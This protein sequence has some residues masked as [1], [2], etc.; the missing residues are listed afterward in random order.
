M[1]VYI[2]FDER[3][4]AAYDVAHASLVSRSSVPLT[5]SP[6]N[7][8]SLRSSGLY[9]RNIDKRGGRFYDLASSAPCSTDFASSRFLTPIIA[10]SGWALFVD[11]DV[12]FLDD[13]AKMFEYCDDSKA[14]VLVKHNY[15][16]MELTKM[17]GQIQTMYNRKNW[18][19][20]MLFNCDHKANKRITLWD[21]NNR[22]GSQLH[23]F[24]WLNDDEIGEL[25]MEWNWLVGVLPKPDR[26]KIAHFTLG[27]PWIDGRQPQEHDEIWLN[28][29]KKHF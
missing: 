20:V 3:E 6:L 15:V 2:G 12:V 11:C 7:E 29:C 21:V 17:D 10:Q 22:K 1:K 9:T 14:V 25:P 4:K 19:S 5:V 13:V 24:F 8:E 16:P 26:P 18:S 23:Q 28:E 27:G